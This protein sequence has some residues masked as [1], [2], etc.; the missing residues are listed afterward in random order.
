MRVG[1]QEIAGENVVEFTRGDV[2]EPPVPLAMGHRETAADFSPHSGAP[3][4]ARRLMTEVLR[5]WGHGG[6]LIQDAQVVLSEL[7]TNAVIHARTSFSVAMRSDERGVRISVRDASV[8]EPAI[9]DPLP[10]SELMATSGRGLPLVAT[11]AKG[12]WG[13]DPGPDGKTVWA[14][15]HG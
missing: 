9:R 13:F 8:A 5:T 14:Q 11:L 2:A 6:S 4:D 7:A 12:R 1:K 10:G 15:L 3:G